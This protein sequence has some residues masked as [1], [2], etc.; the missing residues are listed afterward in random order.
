MAT[1]NED[2]GKLPTADNEEKDNL[3]TAVIRAKKRKCGPTDRE[4]RRTIISVTGLPYA[5]HHS[6]QKVKAIYGNM[7]KQ[8]DEYRALE[9]QQ[10]EI[11]ARLTRAQRDLRSNQKKIDSLN[12]VDVK[13]PLTDEQKCI[14]EKQV[15]TGIY[16]APSLSLSSS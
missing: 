1:G 10:N 7:L 15:R 16:S 12:T 4:M 3:P 6:G 5:A 8:T 13:V 11:K 2:E 14:I 9:D